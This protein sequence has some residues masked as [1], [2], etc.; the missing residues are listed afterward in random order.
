MKE[1]RSVSVIIPTYNR[2]HSIGEAIKSVLEQDIENCRIE[3]IVID[4][5]STDC[6]RDIVTELGPNIR[7]IYQENGGAGAARNRGIKE[8]TGD[9]I[10]FLDSDDRWLPYKLSLQF[11]ILEAFPE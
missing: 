1:A 6:T 3:I 2:A 5:G 4:D 11:K 7:Y 10:A 9:W 8:A